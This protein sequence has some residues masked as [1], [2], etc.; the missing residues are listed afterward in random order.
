VFKLLSFVVLLG[1]LIFIH[2]LGHFIASRLAGIGVKTFSLGFGPRLFGFSRGGTD[3]RISALPLGGYVKMEGE[4]VGDALTGAR[5]E[6]GSRSVLTR[7]LVV[8]AGPFMNLVLALALFPVVFLIGVPVSKTSLEPPVIGYVAPDTPAS[9]AGF[10]EGDLITE[11]NGRSIATWE[12][13]EIDIAA[14]PGQDLKVTVVA[15]GV[16]RIL[17]L[18]PAEDSYGVG[19]AGF[20]PALAPIVGAVS[21]GGAAEQSGIK[22]GDRI[23]SIDGARIAT[24]AMMTR[25]IRS[26]PD[27]PLSLTILRNGVSV[28]IAIVPRRSESGT[29]LIGILPR[30]ETVF[31]RHGLGEAVRLGIKRFRDFTRL[32]FLTMGRLFTFQLSL[33]AM[34]GPIQIAQVSG[35]AA[36]SGLAAFISLMAFMSLQLGLLNLLPIPVLDGGHLFFFAIEAVLRRPLSVEKRELLQQI[37]LVLLVAL[38]ILV[39]IN[40]VRRLVGP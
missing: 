31:V 3:Y 28:P 4:Q 36:E 18:V 33:K 21:A 34:G 23:E 27:T 13:A 25:I 12:E 11:I 2:E 8:A 37:G 26:S 35:A 32:T 29:G 38:M 22:V 6:F 16:R 40:D 7:A 5:T 24:W 17:P 30:E 15:G 9:R 19:Y 14:A 39:S 1:V 20:A 10:A